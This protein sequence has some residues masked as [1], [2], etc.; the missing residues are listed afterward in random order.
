M[1]IVVERCAGLDVHKDLVVACVRA[2][3]PAGERETKIASFS[4]FTDELLALRDWLVSLGVTR[5]GM[6]ATGVYWKPIFYVLEDEL[7]CWLLNARHMR[8]VPGRKTDVGDAQWICQLTEHGLVRASFVPPAEIRDIRELTRYRRSQVEER[9]REAQRLDKVLQDAG[10]SALWN[11]PFQPICAAH[12]RSHEG[13]HDRW[14]QVTTPAAAWTARADVERVE[15]GKRSESSRSIHSWPIVAARQMASGSS[16]GHGE[17]EDP[18]SVAPVM[19][20]EVSGELRDAETETSKTSAEHVE[21]VLTREHS[22]RGKLVRGV[23]LVA[24]RGDEQDLASVLDH[25]GD[26]DFDDPLAM[27]VGHEGVDEAL[28]D[29][30]PGHPG[31]L[32]CV[33]PSVTTVLWCTASSSISPSFLVAAARVIS[34]PLISPSQP[35]CLASSIRARRLS[36]ISSRRAR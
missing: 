33:S 35:S 16:R 7:D 2:P 1:E 27:A 29:G 17:T 3:G 13:I 22:G 32:L 30:G 9:S 15:D 31:S 25:R 20:S 18:G 36:P 4:T 21:D 19:M 24:A 34:R 26:G 8:N 28:G 23:E 11:R 12:V 6:E 14:P 10:F 5:V